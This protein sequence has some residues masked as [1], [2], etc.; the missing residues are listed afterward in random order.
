M[1]PRERNQFGWWA[2]SYEEKYGGSAAVLCPPRYPG[3]LSS[4]CKIS[5]KNDRPC[6]YCRSGAYDPR[7]LPLGAV[8]VSLGE[9]SPRSFFSRIGGVIDGL[10]LTWPTSREAAFEQLIH[11]ASPPERF[12][13]REGY[14]PPEP[15]TVEEVLKTWVMPHL[16]GNSHKLDGIATGFMTLLRAGTP[17]WPRA[18]NM[19]HEASHR[20]DAPGDL[21]AS[22]VGSALHKSWG[23]VAD[24]T[25]SPIEKNSPVGFSEEECCRRAIRTALSHGASAIRDASKAIVK[26]FSIQA[27]PGVDGQPLDGVS[28]RVERI[29]AAS[30]IS[31]MR[32]TVSGLSEAGRYKRDPRLPQ[33]SAYGLKCPVETPDDEK[34]GLVLSLGATARTSSDCPDLMEWLPMPDCLFSDNAKWVVVVDGLRIGKVEDSSEYRRCFRDAQLRRFSEFGGNSWS[35]AAFGV[36]CVTCFTRSGECSGECGVACRGHCPGSQSVGEIRIRSDSSRLVRPLLVGPAVATGVRW[37]GPD[38]LPESLFEL[39]RRGI[40]EYVDAG[41]VDDRSMWIADV[42]SKLSRNPS[43]LEFHPVLHMGVLAGSIPYAHHNQVL[44]ISTPFI[45]CETFLNKLPHRVTA[46]TSPAQLR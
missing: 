23:M 13:N 8:L 12:V 44:K 5:L 30:I 6:I 33:P 32:R 11:A 15:P 2:V 16:E 29:S 40:V 34:I 22:C 14:V 28:E 31:T 42:E 26:A 43:H 21:L 37:G 45:L 39:Y 27:W 1:S 17:G 18:D 7:T 24:A 3:A 36:A 25:R 41:L 19:D 20:M 38:G 10:E 35:E 4:L 9:R 46:T